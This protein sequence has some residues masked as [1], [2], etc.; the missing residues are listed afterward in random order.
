MLSGVVWWHCLLF[1]LFVWFGKNIFDSVCLIY[2]VAFTAAS[3]PLCVY[4]TILWIFVIKSDFLT[5]VVLVSFEIFIIRIHFVDP[6]CFKWDKT[7]S[8]TSYRIIWYCAWRIEP[9]KLFNM[10]YPVIWLAW[11]MAFVNTDDSTWMKNLC[12]WIIVYN[13]LRFLVMRWKRKLVFKS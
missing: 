7:R 10:T 5:T 3:V 1:W 9:S 6:S 8:L 2:F 11:P 12:I 13:K 4:F